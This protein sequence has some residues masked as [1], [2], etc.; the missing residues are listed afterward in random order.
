MVIC[1]ATAYLYSA[2][3]VHWYISAHSQCICCKVNNAISGSV[4]NV[5]QY[6]VD[7]L[8]K[9]AYD[10]EVPP[11]GVNNLQFIA[12]TH[13]FSPPQTCN[14]TSKAHHSAPNRHA[15]HIRQAGSS[16]R[17]DCITNHFEIEWNENISNAG[18][19]GQIACQ[20]SRHLLHPGYWIAWCGLLMFTGSVWCND[21]AHSLC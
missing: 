10:E 2:S 21:I 16:N 3:P 20:W 15:I 13:S 9:R 6:V 17:T 19:Y 1:T 14:T 11:K 8:R 12:Q 18:N 4:C 5:L 7:V